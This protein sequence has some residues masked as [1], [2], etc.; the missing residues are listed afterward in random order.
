[1]PS[2]LPHTSV[3]QN[4]SKSKPCQFPARTY[5]SAS[6]TLRATARS[7]AHAKSAVVSSSTPGVCPTWIPRAVA[8]SRS[9]LSTPT[10]KTDTARRRGAESSRAASTRSV[11]RQRRPSAS[12]HAAW[13]SAEVGGDLPDHTSTSCSPRKRASASPGSLRVT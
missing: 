3:P 8:A 7:N 10:A 5:W 4:W 2:V 9:T 6:T 12:R 1:M 13:R 11:S